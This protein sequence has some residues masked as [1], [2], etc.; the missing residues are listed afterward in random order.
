MWALTI[1]PANY[2]NYLLENF[3][4]FLRSF[5]LNLIILDSE[6]FFISHS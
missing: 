4:Y 2:H 3:S 1:L 6:D 5:S